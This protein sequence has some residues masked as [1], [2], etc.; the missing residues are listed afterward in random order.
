MDFVL[1]F[2]VVMVSMPVLMHYAPTLGLL[3][4]PGER[5]QHSGQVPMVGGLAVFLGL[6]LVLGMHHG[7]DVRA[8][9]LLGG[10][11]LLVAA[12][13]VDDRRE[14]SAKIRFTVQAAACALMI[15]GAGVE[16]RD[17]G[18]LLGF[19]T[20]R[21]GWLVVPVTLFCVVGVTNAINMIDGM[22]GLSA[23]ISLVALAGLAS[24]AMASGQSIELIPELAVLAGGL[25]A[26]LVFNLRLPWRERALAF[27]GDAGTLLLG[28]LLGWMLVERSQGD[29]RI[30]APVTALWLLAVPLIDT[31][32]VMIKR[33]QAGVSMVEADREHLHHAFLRSG[34]DVGVTL[35]LIV[36]TAA[37]LAAAGLA[38]Q[39]AGVPEYLEFAAFLSLSGLYYLGMSRVW[40]RRRFLGRPIE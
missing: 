40:A 31:V 30:I 21:L 12:G 18:N 29:A 15:F 20:L 22:D 37:V 1:A 16:L 3:D 17:F 11:A 4:R 39:W 10:G 33:R 26:Y 27:L 5:K 8:W 19:G 6:L 36:A 35:A 2:T 13:V 23:S 34:R 38:M 14:L 25:C 28:F 24:A 7:G 32:F 9:V